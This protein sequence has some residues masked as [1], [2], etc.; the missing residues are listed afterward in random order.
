M[1]NFGMV[2]CAELVPWEFGT[3]LCARRG[4]LLEY[5]R[6]KGITGILP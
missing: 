1:L 5:R 3:D 2:S 6:S 4:I